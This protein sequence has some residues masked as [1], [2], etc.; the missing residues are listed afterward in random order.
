[1]GPTARH[2][3]HIALAELMRYAAKTAAL[4]KYPTPSGQPAV[5]G[6]RC[7]FHEGECPAKPDFL[8]PLTQK[9]WDIKMLAIS[10]YGS[11][12]H[13]KDAGNEPA[14]TIARPEFTQ[15]ITARGRVWGEQCGAP[16]AEAFNS[17][18]IP[19]V[20]DLRTL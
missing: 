7:W 18:E 16:Y 12:L 20:T 11:Q 4:H 6:V 5:P 1:M 9:F 17:F 8:I 14:T 15:W 2:P 13:R 19:R 3:D 10:C